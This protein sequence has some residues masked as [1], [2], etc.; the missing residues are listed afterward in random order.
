MDL[1]GLR[2]P[3]RRVRVGFSVHHRTYLEQVLDQGLVLD[4]DIVWEKIMEL[5][6]KWVSMAPY[7]LILR[8]DR[9]L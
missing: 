3:S 5:D 2:G 9:A 4:Q 1:Q 8:L 7:E 6:L